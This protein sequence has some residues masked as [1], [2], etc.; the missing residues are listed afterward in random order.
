MLPFVMLGG[1]AGIGG[2]AMGSV[3]SALNGVLTLLGMNSWFLV[4]IQ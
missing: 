3:G 2:S 1:G 4:R